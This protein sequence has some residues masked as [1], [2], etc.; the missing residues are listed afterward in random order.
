[1][2]YQRFIEQ[3]PNLYDNW[4]QES[5][6][7]KSDQFQQV[8]EQVRGMTTANVMQLLNFAVDCMEPDETYCEVGCC[9]GAT[10]IG[11]LFDHPGQMAY[12]VDNFYE[13]DTSGEEFNKLIEH[14]SA[15]S[16]D[17]QVVV[18]NQEFEE[19]LFELREIETDSKIGVYFYN[20]THDYRSQILGLLLVKPFLADK[21]LIIVGNSNV[22][23]AQQA[24]WDFIAAHPQCQ[25]LLDLP[26]PED[27]HPTFWN[28]LQVLS[29]DIKRDYNYDFLNIRNR[30][31]EALVKAICNWG[32]DFEN[33]KKTLDK[34][35]REALA[36]QQSGRY[37]EA[38]KKYKELLQWDK[39]QAYVLLNLGMLYYITN[40]YQQALN[41]LLR[42]LELEP[43]K[44]I[45]HYSVGLVLEKI[46]S[47]P[48]AI[49]AYQQ[50]IALEPQWIDPYN[51]LGNILLQAG[52]LEQA[53]SI[54]RLAIA[55]NPN[56]FGSYLNLGNVL[57]SRHQVDEAVATYEQA[58]HL[59]PRNPDILYNLGVAFDAKNKPEQAALHYGYAYYRQ[60][61]Y[62]EAIDQYQQFLKT[63]TGDVYFYAALANCYKRL[64]QYE[65]SIKIYQEGI[66]L[67]PKTADLYFLLALALQQFGRTQEAIA[68]V[69][70]ASQLL[71]DSLTLKLEK[72]RLLP[73][74]YETEE[75][76]DFYRRRFVQGLEELIQQTSLDTP[77]ARESALMGVGSRTNFYL[78]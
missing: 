35:H 71:P 8:L 46:G 52:E 30:R 9:Q 66:K 33:K 55:A 18:C 58:L 23:A 25:M 57:M 14:V 21:A 13:F 69:T 68:F 51:N 56:H 6:R 45:Q 16:L 39:N 65:E 48:E 17:S 29:W 36:L 41:V 72:Q 76:I 3:L 49:Q 61:E 38:E 1:M 75:E 24:N 34:L 2:D 74:I 42:S 44:A 4:G 31:N 43:S 54:Y 60:G 50:A 12:A 77:E 32:I 27:G 64:N 37:E 19:F 70:E 10:L 26:T 5:V 53:E 40:R 28:G 73:I 7:P 59:K 22:S 78:Q 67:Y 20:D 63:Q 15:F 47:I 11:T 62:Q